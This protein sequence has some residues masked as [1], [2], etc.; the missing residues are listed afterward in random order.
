[1]EAL[2]SAFLP[3]FLALF[4]TRIALEEALDFELLAQFGVELHQGAS[5][6][7]AN[8]SSLSVD[9]AAGRGSEDVKLARSFGRYERLF[10]GDA[11]RFRKK[12]LFERTRVNLPVPGRRNTRATLD[13]RRPVP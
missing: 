11:L 9:A 12:V 4:A 13:L 8:G 1:L 5:N 2:P 7:H 6:A 3:I 10:G